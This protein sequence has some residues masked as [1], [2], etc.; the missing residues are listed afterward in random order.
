MSIKKILIWLPAI[1]MAM[2]IF[3]FSKQD[4][5]ESSGLSYKAADIILTV[6]DKAGIIDCN[7]NNRESMIEAVQF[8]I[9]KAAH[10]TEYA[11]FSIFV[12]IALI[13]DGIKGVR[14]P[15][16]SA[17]IAIAFAATDEF[18]QTFV[19]GRYGCVLDV[20]IDAAGSIIGLIILYIKICVNIKAKNAIILIDKDIMSAKA[21][22]LKVPNGTL[23]VLKSGT[24]IK[25]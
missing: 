1:V 14:I 9:R 22:I 5:E 13:V 7:E 23:Y 24:R 3:G 8:P 17:V 20:L 4:G 12:M 10:M 21:L 11:I 19:P 18:H 6:C 25:I 15:V 16:I 2:I